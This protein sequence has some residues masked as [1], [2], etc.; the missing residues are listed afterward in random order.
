MCLAVSDVVDFSSL[1]C[2]PSGFAVPVA[3][4]LVEQVVPS[5]TGGW[6]EQAKDVISFL[7]WE[8]S[9]QG[10]D[11]LLP[12]GFDPLM[13]LKR[14]RKGGSARALL[15]DGW[16][17]PHADGRWPLEWYAEQRCK[18]HAAAGCS[19]AVWVGGFHRHRQAGNWVYV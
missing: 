15:S 12:A 7:L 17:R 18:Q 6:G 11:G 10:P 14:R 2:C 8:M 16:P 9:A 5:D 1:R 3:D 4:A 13:G 19:A